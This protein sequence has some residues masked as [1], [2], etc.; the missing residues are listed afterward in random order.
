MLQIQSNEKAI[1]FTIVLQENVV[2][3]IQYFIYVNVQ[4]EGKN[5]GRA[6]FL[7]SKNNGYCS[8]T[9]HKRKSEEIL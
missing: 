4:Y 2:F 3:M 5:V 1:L 9:K 7:Q 8:E 6:V